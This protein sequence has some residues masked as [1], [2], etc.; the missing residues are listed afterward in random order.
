MAQFNAYPAMRA[1][2]FDL[3]EIMRQSQQLRAYRSQNKL[4]D[5]KLRE[6]QSEVQRQGQLRGLMPDV[7]REAGLGA[8]SQKALALDPSMMIQLLKIPKAERDRAKEQA[9]TLGNLALGV[10]T[11][12]AIQRTAMWRQARESAI[13]NGANPQN[14]P[15]AYTQDTEIKLRNWVALA[16]QTKTLLDQVS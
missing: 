13:A 10:L 6:A 4:Q 7:G 14:V 8:S 3:P 15:E 12:P 9:T 2:T 5:F 1:E 16:E 11:A